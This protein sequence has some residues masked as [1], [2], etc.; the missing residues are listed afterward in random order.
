M[1]EIK[2]AVRIPPDIKRPVPY[3]NNAYLI[4]KCTCGNNFC[5]FS[6]GRGLYIL[7]LEMDGRYET[8][9]WLSRN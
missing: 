3:G 2:T 7:S 6:Q 8:T 9:W 5:K 4:E 1:M